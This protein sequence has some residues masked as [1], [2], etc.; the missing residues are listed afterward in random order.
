MNAYEECYERGYG[1]T[2]MKVTMSGRKWRRQDMHHT[3][4]HTALARHARMAALLAEA[5]V[6][7]D[8]TKDA[9]SEHH[10]RERA[11]LPNLHQAGDACC[12][13]QLGLDDVLEKSKNLKAQLV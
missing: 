6:R 7:H 1:S 4:P 11:G 9:G 12:G 3:H 5:P 13:A 8:L 10:Q 2:G